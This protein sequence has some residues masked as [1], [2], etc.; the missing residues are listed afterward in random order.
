MC[1]SLFGFSELNYLD[2]EMTEIDQELQSIEVE[3]A[4]IDQRKAELLGR[5]SQLTAQRQQSIIPSISAPDYSALTT[6]QK[7]E[8]FINLFQGH[9]D[10]Y[11]LRWENKQGRSGYSVACANEWQQ[12]ICNK[13]KVKCGECSHRAYL[14]LDKQAVYDHLSGKKTVGLYPLSTEDQCWLLAADFD[15]ADWHQA[16]TAF[17]HVCEN[18]DISCAIERSRSGNGAHVWIFFEQAIAAKDARRLGFALLDKA[19]EQHAGLSFESYDRLFP[20]Q[21]TMPAG[22]FG[23]L[24]A[25]PL[26]CLPRKSGNSVFINEHF[27]PYLDQWGY[28]ASVLKVSAK[29][30]YECLGRV[31]ADNGSNVK[32]LPIADVKPWERSIPVA[33]A[34]ISDCPEVLELVLANKLYLPIAPLPQALVARI[35]RIASFSNPVFFKTQ[36][37]R[38]ST[39]GIPRFICLAEIEQG[40]L[41]LPRGCLDE[42]VALLEEQSIN[43][44]MEDKRSS[45]QRLKGIKFL[46]ELRKDQK[47]AVTD[48]CKHDVGVLQAP[49]AF[50]KTV[51]AIGMIHKRKVNTL[52]LVHNRQ[53]LDQWRERLT[54]FLSGV[55]IGVIGA[56]KR[57]ATGQIDVAT[58]Q[59]LIN[60]KDNTVDGVLFQYGQIIIDECHH[61]SAPNYERLMSEVYAR[62]VV[63]ITATPARRDGH[64][65]IIFMQAGPIRH[66]AKAAGQQE[67][68]QRVVKRSLYHAPP[69]EIT[70]EEA[71]PHIA[72]VYR[73]LMTHEARNQQIVEDVLVS[74]S[75]Q[76]NPIL[77]T[78]RREHAELLGELLGQQGVTYELLR[79]GMGV[80][81]R[82][83]VTERLA[84][85]QVLIA[86]GKYIGEG[87]D[88]PRLD[89]LFLVLPIS[90][91]GSLAQY[92]G[93]IHRQAEGKEKVVIYDYVDYSLPMLE[94]MFR[95]RQRGYEALGYT[96]TEPA[97]EAGLVQSSLQLDTP[98][99]PQ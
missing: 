65:P 63:G 15:K 26:Q 5:Q 82:K 77:L 17:R 56:G 88:L 43:L 22:G 80:K 33:K 18:W 59:S 78:E 68:E 98:I 13:P 66:V 61:I 64:Q 57:K 96:I 49:S 55:D 8:L 53:L 84:D 73:W 28:L 86:T 35:K 93:R 30:L 7:V 40:Y 14:P 20:N 34:Q 11:A 71:R 95:K 27:Q 39:N 52:I 94:R 38:F 91:K 41:A 70:Q 72:D 85:T 67:F 58:Y 32:H 44:D 76:R 81:A 25:L 51:A 74:L 12:G 9:E 47:R 50:G 69:L 21:D 10:I 4:A 97:K 31:S 16:V 29:H 60:R 62:Y 42:V 45:G 37:L 54:S 79:G 92:A 1:I 3:L 6:L 2:C 90:W 23:N 99:V 46:G 19:M 89:T 48:L 83:A 36:A 75:E 87:F 24:I